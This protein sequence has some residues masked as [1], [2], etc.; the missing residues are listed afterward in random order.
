MVTDTHVRTHLDFL[1]AEDQR[2][3]FGESALRLCPTLR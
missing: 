3:I 1:R 2:W